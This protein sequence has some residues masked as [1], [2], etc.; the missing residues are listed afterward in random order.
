MGPQYSFESAQYVTQDEFASWVAKRMSDL[1]RCELLSGRIVR[2]PPSGWPQGETAAVIGAGLLAYVRGANLG[3]VFGPD[4]GFELPSGDTVAPDAAFVSTQ[5]WAATETHVPGKFLRVVPEL[6]VEVLSPSTASRDRGEK[7]SS[8]SATRWPNTGSW[9]PPPS[10]SP[11]LPSTPAATAP[12]ASSKPPI[13]STPR[14]FRPH[15]PR[16]RPADP[17]T[18]AIFEAARAELIAVEEGLDFSES[19]DDR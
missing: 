7:S 11:A 16:R 2:S 6:V 10:R 4:Q 8:T 18:Q 14:F 15:P 3:R 19:D 9:I 17:V 1:E 12:R 5:R 13:R